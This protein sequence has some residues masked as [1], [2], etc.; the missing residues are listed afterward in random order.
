MKLTHTCFGLPR[1][2]DGKN[3]D[4]GR[5]H[6]R[7]ASVIAVLADG[8][9]SS[10]EGGVAAARAVEMMID[11]Y[12]TRPLAW[13]PRRAIA[14]FVRHINSIFFRE[15]QLR[16]GVPE[17]L[18]TLS[19]VVLESGRLYGGNVGDSPV[20]LWRAGVLSTLSQ[21]HNVAQPGMGHGLTRALG[22]EADVEP[23]TFEAEFQNGDLIVLCSDGVSEPLKTDKIAALCAK[24][25]TARHFVTAAREA[26]S[27]VPG[28][29][30]DAT[31]IV[32]HV[33]E[34][35]WGQAEVRRPLE[36]LKAL[37]AG[38][39][40]DGYRLLREL[41]GER[42]WMA[43]DAAGSLF[44]LKFP[45]LEA[46]SDE[47]RRDGFLREVWQ[48]TRINS[49]D[50]VRA[51]VPK[52]ETLRCYAMEYVE[53]GTLRDALSKGL[54]KVEDAVALATFL[55]RACQFLLARDHAHGDIKPENILVL[56]S[57]NAEPRFQLLDLGSSA[58]LFSVTSRA[59]TPSYLAPERF[60]GSPLSE[61]TELFAI[62]VTLYEAL[63]GRFPY[64]EIERFQTPRFDSG[65]KPASAYNSA[66][67]PWL[68]AVVLRAI[69]VDPERRYQNYSELGY[70]LSHP[71]RV[72][73]FHGK[74]AS[75]LERDPLRFYQRLSL[76]LFVVV[77]GLILR[78]LTRP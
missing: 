13:S 48:A 78:L 76:L 6:Q 10:R 34:R 65:G 21:A 61:R 53:A 75:L 30:D 28:Q 52:G 16:Y 56:P 41:G 3:D 69:A 23:Y 49:Q 32:L 72:A 33:V 62:G 36:V 40:I 15:S 38:D 71:E 57:D 26:T 77:L 27:S 51:F 17:L 25:S 70:E 37:K 43:E 8:L 4:A 1:N 7:D 39:N 9:G 66:V 45:P 29:D 24:R 14:E 20:Y 60:R 12:L 55:V 46:A 19:V 68:D 18:S 44:V 47:V 31:A 50:F 2:K 5:V 11:Y 35:D 73:A 58:E 59:G 74:N 42:V 63:T 54:L 64:G 67:P 22:L